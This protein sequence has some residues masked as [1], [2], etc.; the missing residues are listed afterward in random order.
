M[1]WERRVPQR[2][3]PP[4]QGAEWFARGLA[5]TDCRI[6]GGWL[7]RADVMISSCRR[8][9]MLSG[10]ALALAQAMPARAAGSI[11]A[12]ATVLASTDLGH[13]LPDLL[14]AFGSIGGGSV[15]TD[16]HTSADIDRRVRKGEAA[17]II[18]SADEAPIIQLAR[19]GL[20]EDGGTALA[21]GRL[22]LI[23]NR[24]STLA[25]DI[26]LG[27]VA[28]AAR[29]DVPFRVALA[30]PDTTPYGQRAIDVLERW[31]VN[32]L[33]RPRFVYTDDVAEAVRLVASGAAA[34]G[35]VAKSLTSSPSVGRTLH[36]SDIPH[37][38]H[39]PLIQ[40]MALVKGAS[41]EA[42]RFYGFLKTDPAQR[43]LS[44]HGYAVPA[45]RG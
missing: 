42:R 36:A 17:D 5:G 28:E 34:V 25:D 31:S 45:L 27:A 3:A 12:S 26:S 44:R 32:D 21:E 24:R 15:H 7:R 39:R 6:A 22:S 2:A 1:P 13:A 41:A 16:Y 29:N 10:A 8:T 11:P 37:G 14:R 35:L 38:W 30:D 9:V 40:R 4:L 20:L 18:I 19:E 43:L 33:L 23:I